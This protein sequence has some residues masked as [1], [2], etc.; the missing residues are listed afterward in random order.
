[1]RNDVAQR[2]QNIIEEMDEEGSWLIEREGVDLIRVMAWP[3]FAIH[4]GLRPEYLTTYTRSNAQDP[5]I[6]VSLFKNQYLM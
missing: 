6:Q 1:M 5:H 2:W 4:T 3:F